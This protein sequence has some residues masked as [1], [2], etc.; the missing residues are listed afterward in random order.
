MGRMSWYARLSMFPFAAGQFGL[1]P[2]AFYAATC[3]WLA[4]IPVLV[5]ISLITV[6]RSSPEPHCAMKPG[7][8]PMSNEV[9]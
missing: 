4:G 1:G 7:R 3:Q 2:S 5:P 6:P 9:R 8:P